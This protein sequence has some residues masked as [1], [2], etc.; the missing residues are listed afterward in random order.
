MW[1]GTLL[2]PAKKTGRQHRFSAIAGGP[3][4]VAVIPL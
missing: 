3:A 2:L 1:L 4:D